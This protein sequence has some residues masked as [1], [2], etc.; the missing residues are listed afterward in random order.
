[1]PRWFNVANLFTL[2]RLILVPYVMGAILDGRH[3]RAL[4]LFLDRKSTRLNSSHLVISYAAFSLEKKSEVPTPVRKAT[5]TNTM[6]IASV[7]VSAG[8]ATCSVFF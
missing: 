4:E 7:A 2:L 3:T 5:G 6:Q 1:M 8:S